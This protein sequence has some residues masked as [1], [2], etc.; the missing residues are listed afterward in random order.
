MKRGVSDFL[1]N[2][3]HC[4]TGHTAYGDTITLLDSVEGHPM[5]SSVIFSRGHTKKGA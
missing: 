4:P 5:T 2:I 3:K 1:A